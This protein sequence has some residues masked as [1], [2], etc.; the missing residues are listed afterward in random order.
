MVDGQVFKSNSFLQPGWQLQMPDSADASGGVRTQSGDSAPA[1]A[2][3]S[4]RVVTVHSGDYLSKIAEKELGD[5]DEW[6]ALFEASRGKPQPDG[7]PTIS[8]PDVVYAGQQVTVPGAQPDQHAPPHDGAPGDETE[9]REAPPPAT[10][11][12]DGE[13]KPGTGSEDEEATVP[14]STARLRQNRRR[15]G[16]RAAVPPSSPGRNRAL[17]PRHGPAQRQHFPLCRLA[18][19]VG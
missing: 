11:K 15:P 19:G 1:A 12:P 3:E 7:L 9:N 18:V 2:E 6:P 16:P 10:Q 5:G 4:A 17:L 13:Q 14:G 8:D